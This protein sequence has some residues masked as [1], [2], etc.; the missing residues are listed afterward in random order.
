[1]R[2]RGP[3]VYKAV[4]DAGMLT[5]AEMLPALVAGCLPHLLRQVPPPNGE[6]VLSPPLRCLWE[7]LDR[8]GQEQSLPKGWVK[9]R[10]IAIL[11]S[12]NWKQSLNASG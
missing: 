1:M 5:W 10:K 6:E 3:G 12:H 4:L 7:I 8:K 9:N 2:D 11:Y